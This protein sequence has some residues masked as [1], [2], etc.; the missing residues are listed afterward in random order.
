MFY[1]STL[2]YQWSIILIFYQKY[3]FVKYHF[4]EKNILKNTKYF[5]KKKYSLLDTYMI[6]SILADGRYVF[7]DFYFF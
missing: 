2:R 5:I 3:F 4:E 7:V 1:K 6:L